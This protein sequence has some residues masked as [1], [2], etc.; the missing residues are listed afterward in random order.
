MC[1]LHKISKRI[2]GSMSIRISISNKI[3]CVYR[4]C[5]YFFQSKDHLHSEKILI[6]SSKERMIERLKKTICLIF[7][8]QSKNELKKKIVEWRV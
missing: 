4:I 6:K 5:S 3:Y 1:Y 2:L 8:H 7:N